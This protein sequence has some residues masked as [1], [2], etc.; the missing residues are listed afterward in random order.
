[1][2]DDTRFAPAFIRLS[3]RPTFAVPIPLRS[4]V[5]GLGLATSVVSA[6]CGPSQR[7]GNGNHDDS[8]TGTPADAPGTVLPDP[9]TCADAV[10]SRSY[11]GCDFWPTV[12][13]NIVDET[14][15][16]AIVV[17]NPGAIPADITVTGPNNVHQTATVAPKQL[18][19]LYL[20]WVTELKGGFER[21]TV[22]GAIE[23]MGQDF[24]ASVLKPNGA[25]HLVSSRP[26]VAYQFSPLEYHGV[27]GP[28]GKNWSPCP[29]ATPFGGCF[30]YTNDA[31]LLLPS[32]AMTGNYRVAS[33]GHSWSGTWL[34]M[35]VSTGQPGIMAITAT[36]DMTTVNVHLS[37]RTTIVGGGGVPDVA[38]GGFTTLTLNAGDVAELFAGDNGVTGYPSADFSGSVVIADKP[39]QIIGAVPCIGNPGNACDHIEE[40]V[41]PS[42]TLGHH[43]VVTVPT[44]PKGTPI[45]HSVRLI[46][47]V[48]NT[49][50]TFD[51]PIA[52]APSVINAGQVIDL[53]PTM[54][55][56]AQISRVTQ[57]FEVSGDHA[58]MV[59][60]F[61]LSASQLDPN[62][63]P[64]HPNPL[65][66]GDPSLSLAVAVE[67]Y[68]T[69]YVF[70][71]PTDYDT[72]YVDIV[73][74][75]TSHL[76]LDGAGVT[77]SPNPLTSAFGVL[78]LR[79]SNTTGGAHVLT[80]DQP[81]GIQVLGYGS[82]TSY[83]YPGG[84]N[85]TQISPPV[86]E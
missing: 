26:V 74:P 67:Q 27:G 50:L 17:S 48:D 30:S 76:M 60:S 53:S 61:M 13:A 1:M 19:T 22:D 7:S 43:Y 40:S 41:L 55:T 73:M 82:Y 83:Q 4:F 21:I 65:S 71:A 5:L 35:D 54:V 23:Y 57:D 12:T 16:F 45:G 79:L 10:A 25:Y 20:P 9:V 85:L 72:N 32:T 36:A 69:S 24:A 47:N 68:R 49:N 42:E 59:E 6:A 46:G 15:D 31:S 44:G 11:I 3:P 2:I 70:L 58:F 63:D 39:V 8:G 66:K 56:P 14:F 75:M 28:A 34:G 64:L 33:M 29:L 51:P 38:A 37:S 86:I 52:G 80:G 84:L 62:Y 81:F 77:S 78:R 18:V